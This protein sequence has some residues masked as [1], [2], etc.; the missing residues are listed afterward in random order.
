MILRLLPLLLLVAALVAVETDPIKVLSVYDG[1][2]LTA[3]LADGTTAKVRLL[4]L[5]TPELR[6]NRNE[7]AR[8]ESAEAARNQLALACE[9]ADRLTLWSPHDEIRKDRYG[10]LLAVVKLYDGD[11]H[12]SAQALMI[13]SGW[14]VYWRK[15]GDAPEPMH[16]SMLKLQG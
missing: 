15:Y 4:W 2:T 6:N 1:D 11:A 5:D 16:S 8:P 9:D 7:T 12:I 14:S 3:E 13:A 10:R